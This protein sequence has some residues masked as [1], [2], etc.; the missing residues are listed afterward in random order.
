MK[1][2]GPFKVGENKICSL[3]RN[4]DIKEI[5]VLLYQYHIRLSKVSNKYF[6]AC[7]Y[8]AF[9]IDFAHSFVRIKNA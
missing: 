6:L 3:A 5:T 1:Y 2:Y 4:E 7:L 9:S 8:S